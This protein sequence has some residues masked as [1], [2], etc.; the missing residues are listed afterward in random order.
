MSERE[1]NYPD[2]IARDQLGLDPI[3]ANCG[4]D[5]SDYECEAEMLDGGRMRCLDC[6]IKQRDFLVQLLVRLFGWEDKSYLHAVMHVENAVNNLRADLA[7]ARWEIGQMN[8][9]R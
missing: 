2:V 7:V 3:C 5:L 9:E 1:V 6:V 4:K 8:E